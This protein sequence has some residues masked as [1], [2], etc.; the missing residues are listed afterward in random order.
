MKD[1]QTGIAQVVAG[2]AVAGQGM[3]RELAA[4]R[5]R[6]L[7]VGVGGRT[8]DVL[9]VAEGF[10]VLGKDFDAIEQPSNAHSSG[11]PDSWLNATL[12]VF[13]YTDGLIGS[14]RQSVRAVGDG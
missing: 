5:G 6:A 11:K 12:W 14:K 3:V 7:A 4:G 10:F 8:A 1:L 2:L 9:T 13:L